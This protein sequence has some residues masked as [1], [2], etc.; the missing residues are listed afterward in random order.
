MATAIIS[1]QL[2]VV[3]IVYLVGSRSEPSVE[4]QITY[5]FMLAISSY[6]YYLNNVKSFYV[7]CATSRLF[8]EKLFKGLAKIFPRYWSICGYEFINCQRR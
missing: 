1:L 4:K 7:S 6:V 8:R 5:Y 2:M 3:V